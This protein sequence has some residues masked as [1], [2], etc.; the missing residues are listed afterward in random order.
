M[1]SVPRKKME[2]RLLHQPIDTS[3]SRVSG[4][5]HLPRIDFIFTLRTR[6]DHVLCTLLP[7]CCAFSAFGSS[8]HGFL[9]RRLGFASKMTD[10]IKT[11]IK[12]GLNVPSL[13]SSVI[14]D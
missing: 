11:D 9:S 2:W 14:S 12:G 3:H 10:L 6:A 13:L 8:E 1:W 4:L 5:R 7:E